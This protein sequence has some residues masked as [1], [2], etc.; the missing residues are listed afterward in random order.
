VRKCGRSFFRR[1]DSNQDRQI[2]AEEWNDCTVNGN[3]YKVD[4]SCLI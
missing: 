4:F 2:D 1:C 3:G